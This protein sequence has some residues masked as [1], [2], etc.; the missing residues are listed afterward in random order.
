MTKRR[1]EGEGERSHMKER[2]SLV[3]LDFED[4]RQ[5]KRGITLRG[6]NLLLHFSKILRCFIT[7]LDDSLL[8][9]GNTPNTT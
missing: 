3:F 7:P 9:N 8:Y 5:I 2:S 6:E 4:G 1:R